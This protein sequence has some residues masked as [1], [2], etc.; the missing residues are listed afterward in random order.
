[1]AAL[2]TQPRKKKKEEQRLATPLSDTAHH[3]SLRYCGSVVIQIRHF[4]LYQLSFTSFTSILKV[5]I[6]FMYIF[7]TTDL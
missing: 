5:F 3:Q 1:M 6:G 4:L 2:L 7:S